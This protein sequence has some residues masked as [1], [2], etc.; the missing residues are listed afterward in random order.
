MAGGQTVSSGRGQ[1]IHWTGIYTPLSTHIVVLMIL[2][3]CCGNIG[4]NITYSVSKCIVL[5][6]LKIHSTVLVFV[7]NQYTHTSTLVLNY[8]SQDHVNK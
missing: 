1:F 6:D 7:F 4:L 5:I 2:I 8:M 3:L